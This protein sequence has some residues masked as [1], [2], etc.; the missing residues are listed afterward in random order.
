M[1]SF[2]IYCSIFHT[3]PG[4]WTIQALMK[5]LKNSY[6]LEFSEDLVAQDGYHPL[7]NTIRI[8]A[9]GNKINVEFSWNTIE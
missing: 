3:G 1:V 5:R 9:A 2:I 4:I 7:L 8:G 6:K